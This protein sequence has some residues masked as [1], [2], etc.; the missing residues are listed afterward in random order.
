MKEAL[1]VD[2][3]MAKL[4]YST[5]SKEIKDALEGHFGKEFFIKKKYYEQVG[6]VKDAIRILNYSQEKLDRIF[7]PDPQDADEE[8][9]NAHEEIKLI[10]KAICFLAKFKAD[11]SNP[12]Q[13]KWWPWFVWDKK[14]SAFVFSSTDYDC[15]DTNT[16]VG[17]RLSL[18]DSES[19]GYVG[20]KF[21]STYNKFLK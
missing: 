14:T 1:S 10:I 11:Y 21:I 20:Q 3:N 17:V 19:A 5:A 9:S 8:A 2:E 16:H 12:K 15:D 4:F 18:P 7:I 13:E 6:D